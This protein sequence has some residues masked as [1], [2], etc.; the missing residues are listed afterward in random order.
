MEGHVDH[1]HVGWK[2]ERVAYLGQRLF[3]KLQRRFNSSGRG[4]AR[5]KVDRKVM[6][7]DDED[8]WNFKRGIM[9]SARYPP[10]ES[11]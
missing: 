10:K 1:R 2:R 9:Y 6:L 7:I 4:Y 5:R 11:V 8:P 3:G